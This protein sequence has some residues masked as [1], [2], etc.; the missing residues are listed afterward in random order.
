MRALVAHPGTQHAFRLAV[1]LHRLNA[2]SVFHT[3]MALPQWR[4][5]DFVICRGIWGGARRTVELK[6]CRSIVSDCSP[7][8]NW[9]PLPKLTLV[10]MRSGFFIRGTS[11]FSTPSRQ[12][13][14]R[15]PMS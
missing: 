3:G 1:E 4:M 15:K 6:G 12:R 9:C 11:A 10:A 14:W 2:L 8:K 7:L 5:L 13:I